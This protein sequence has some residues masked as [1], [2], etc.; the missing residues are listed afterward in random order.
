MNNIGAETIATGEEF[1]TKID[2][3][4]CTM[5]AKNCA[6]R[7][8]CKWVSDLPFSCTGI[9]SSSCIASVR[10]FSLLCMYSIFWTAKVISND[11]CQ[12]PIALFGSLFRQHSPL[13][14]PGV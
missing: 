12:V 8:H 6:K 1:L 9:A 10:Q 7:Q 3:N 13:M 2:W 4:M 11:C 5:A 14:L